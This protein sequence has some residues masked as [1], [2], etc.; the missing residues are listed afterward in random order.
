MAEKVYQQ[1][2]MVGLLFMVP[3]VVG[4]WP[5]AGYFLGDFLGKKFGWPDFMAL[6][7]AGLGFISGIMELTMIFK[8]LPKDK[9]T[10]NGKVS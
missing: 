7:F 3:V 9:K 4:V 2:K 6:I 1:I 8:A 10:D 5:I